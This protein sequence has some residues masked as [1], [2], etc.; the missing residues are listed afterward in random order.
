MRDFKVVTLIPLCYL[1]FAVNVGLFNMKF[2]GFFGL[3]KDHQT[4]APSLLF[5]SM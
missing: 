3:Y 5:S 4:D 1:A 2:S